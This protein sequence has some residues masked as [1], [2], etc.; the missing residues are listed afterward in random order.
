MRQRAQSAFELFLFLARRC[1][2]AQGEP[3]SPS[4]E[5]LCRACGLDAKHA[6]SRAA[7]SRL[8][9]RLRK[10]F[11]IID[12]EPV[13]RRRPQIRLRPIDATADVLN[14]RHY[15][16]LGEPWDGRDRAVFDALGSR[17]FAAEY[18]YILA[19]YEAAL[20]RT[21]HH[22][23]YWFYPLD[24]FSRTYHI[25]PRFASLGL[26]ALMDL[27][28]MRIS[29]GRR[30][31]VAAEGE[32]GRANRYY[33]EGLPAIAERQ[34]HLSVLADQYPSTFELARALSVELTN[35][36]TVRNVEGLCALFSA[37]G[38][39][40]VREVLVRLSHYRKGNPRRQLAYVRAVVS[41]S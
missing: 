22:R 33:F 37:Y 26:Q 1:L 23:A 40:K 36:P 4:H 15:V 31:M 6:N 39:V 21:K 12:Y 10:T 34:R 30:D 35:G 28:V 41:R 20:A 11:G 16:Y 25:S 24:R 5:D 14:P 27:G 2:K 7:L 17:A 13:R 9:G 8:L 32:Y 38:E 3:I 19:T 18:T 29:Y